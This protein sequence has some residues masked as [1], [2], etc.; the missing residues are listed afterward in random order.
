MFANE[1]DLNYT[2]ASVSGVNANKCKSKRFD[3]RRSTI[4]AKRRGFERT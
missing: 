2:N 1:S 4:F 3:L